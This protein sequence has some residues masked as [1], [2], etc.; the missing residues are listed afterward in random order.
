M[1]DGLCTI[2]EI[3]QVAG[4]TV[5]SSGILGALVMN[6]THPWLDLNNPFLFYPDLEQGGGATYNRSTG[7]FSLNGYDVGNRI[8][9]FW[10]GVNGSYSANATETVIETGTFS[11]SPAPVPEPNSFALLA[12]ML[13]AAAIRTRATKRP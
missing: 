5:V 9:L 4:G 1:T 6:G 13:A 2:C 10:D 11:V 7:A 12:T 3:S 8:S